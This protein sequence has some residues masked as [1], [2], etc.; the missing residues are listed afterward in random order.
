MALLGIVAISVAL[1]MIWVVRVPFFQ[2]PDESAHADYAFAIVSAERPVLAREGRPATD[3]DPQTA[4]LETVT[5]FREMRYNANGRAPVGY[6]TAAYF[7]RVDRGAPRPRAT[8]LMGNQP[9]LPYVV[10]S[11]APLYYVME[12]LVIGVAQTATHSLSFSYFA[13]RALNVATLAI[14]LFLTYGIARELRVG[15]WL[16]LA[17]TAIAGW[18]PLTSWVSSYVQPDN[19]A[20]A[21]VSFTLYLSLRLRRLPNFAD[22]IMLGIALGL[23]SATKLQYLAAVGIPV[24]AAQCAQMHR[25]REPMGARLTS[26][27]ILFGPALAIGAISAWVTSS[28][29]ELSNSRI[30]SYAG[31]LHDAARHGISSAAGYVGAMLQWAFYVIFGGGI[32]FK[33]YWGAISWTATPILFGN[34][35]ATEFIDRVLLIGTLVTLTLVT[36]RAWSSIHRLVLVGRRRSWATAI[37][38]ALADTPFNSYAFFNL[39]MIVLFIYTGGEIGRQGR[40]WLPFLLPAT[41]CA[42]AY[43]P[44]VLRRPGRPALSALMT[45]GLLLYAI[46]GAFFGLKTLEA[47][48]YGPALRPSA[49]D[50]EAFARID[51]VDG[52]P[53]FTPLGLTT[54]RVAADAPISVEGWALD[55]RSGVVARN[56]TLLV[57]GRRIHSTYGFARPDIAARQHDD[58]FLRCGFR[59]T[60]GANSL[61]PG[62]HDLSL[63]VIERS[64]PLGVRSAVPVRL[65]I[66]PATGAASRLRAEGEHNGEPKPRRDAG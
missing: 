26:L 43:A 12:A 14:S 30:A 62:R 55:S 54:L 6:G 50:L 10:G 39:I 31:G 27:A 20:F 28:G 18:L 15:R 35:A 34:E 13:A 33:T 17:A 41:L 32:G 24:L 36:M 49:A 63:L 8:F 38:I 5:G 45:G 22:T 47:R 7:A 19:L 57:D 53:T 1:A 60:I 2:S 65:E 11:Y 42:I 48:F 23:L 66:L 29:G 59:G 64:R 61:A 44:R 16:A 40:Y 51:L 52:R 9:R 3:V 58:G 37:E 56:V 4:Y 46:G 25:R 21:L